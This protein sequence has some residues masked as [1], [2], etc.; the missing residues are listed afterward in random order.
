VDES[1]EE[2][3]TLQPFAV[4]HVDNIW[5]RFPDHDVGRSL[6][7]SLDD[8][9]VRSVQQPISSQSSKDKKLLHDLVEAKLI[10]PRHKLPEDTL[11]FFV[12]INLEDES[13]SVQSDVVRG[14]KRFLTDKEEDFQFP[15]IYR[16]FGFCSILFKAQVVDYFRI[17]ELPNWIGQEFSEFG[18]STETYLVHG[19]EQI[20]G[21]ETIGEATFNAIKG[22]DLFV[23][24][25]IPEL[26]E[27]DYNE[28]HKYEVERFLKDI[29]H[30][31][32]QDSDLTQKDKKLLHDYL[33]G[34]LENDSTKMA[35]TLFTFFY[36]IE[37]FLRE[38]HKP[39]LTKFIGDGETIGEI[40]R[41]VNS[42]KQSGKYLTLPELLKFYSIVNSR[43]AVAGYDNVFSDHKTR[44][45]LGDIRNKVAHGD[46]N[47]RQKWDTVLTELLDHLPSIEKLL[48]LVEHVTGN[49][50]SGIY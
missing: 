11:R 5:N 1:L 18:I 25:I 49:R 17:A 38:N 19:T 29:G 10:V 45:S 44:D 40:Y 32:R 39:F 13:P 3:R 14:I 22:R 37:S 30:S 42:D 4:T 24:F 33:I 2:C 47:F 23:Q 9:N 7:E 27:R 12:S 34:F 48:Y 15:S 46:L 36:E 20:A 21:D 16:G 28:E 26:Y 6:L 8:K 43:S 50:Y 31:Q 41:E 35:Q